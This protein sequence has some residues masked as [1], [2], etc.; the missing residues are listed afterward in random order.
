MKFEPKWKCLMANT[1]SHIFTPEQCQDIINMGHSLKTQD[2]KVGVKD[3]KG[4]EYD[5]KKRIKKLEPGEETVIE[6]PALKTEHKIEYMN[7]KDLLN[8]GALQAIK[9]NYNE[10]LTC[11]YIYAQNGKKGV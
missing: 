2:A 10:A 5:T 1:T 7:L 8:E 4:G 9:G 11:Q 6:I 3:D